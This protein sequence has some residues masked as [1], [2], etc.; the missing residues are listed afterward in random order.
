M[1]YEVRRRAPRAPRPKR[2]PA[3][4]LEGI[5]K[6]DDRT[7]RVSRA[8]LTQILDD[9]SRLA[10]AARI[11]PSI[12]DGAPNGFKLYG[13]RRSSP[14]AQLGFRNGDTVHAVNDI[15]LTSPDEALRAY[16]RLRH[17]RRITVELTRRGKP[18]EI[19]MEM[20]E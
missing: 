18:H 17:A 20:T 11:I 10:R 14:Y 13:I 5:T 7:F 16:T 9:P 15:P 2:V 1:R 12:E 6:L 19:V 8:T 4:R 3:E